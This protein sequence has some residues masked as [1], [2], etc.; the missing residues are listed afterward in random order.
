MAFTDHIGY[1]DQH[2]FNLDP[3]L[4]ALEHVRTFRPG[5]HE[6]EARRHLNDFLFQK[7]EKVLQLA[8]HLS[9][10]EKARLSLSLIT[11]K[12]TK[13]LLLDE[14]TNNLDLET[15]EDVIQV[16]KAYLGAMVLVSQE[17]DMTHKTTF[18]MGISFNVPCA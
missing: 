3:K 4:S 9:G 16:L 5:W 6:T 14:I 1:L 11:A 13:L 18:K 7:N 17:I 8:V 15:K 12:T 10:G 2:Y